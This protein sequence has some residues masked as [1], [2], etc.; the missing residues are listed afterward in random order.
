AMPGIVVA[1]I[2]SIGRIV[3]ESAALLLTAGTAAKIP[4]SL[5][6]SGSTLTVKAYTLAKEEANIE[7]ASAIGS[8]IIIIILI[9]NA[10]SK[11]LSRKIT[12]I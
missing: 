2:L 7:L 1:V 9:L 4:S 10:L 5:F 8:V 11:L 12:K 3:G 6:E